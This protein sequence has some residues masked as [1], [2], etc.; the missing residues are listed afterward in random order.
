MNR[1][2]I[3]GQ[4]PPERDVFY[5][6]RERSGRDVTTFRV[7]DGVTSLR[8]PAL[9]RLRGRPDDC[10]GRDEAGASSWPA[11]PG[12]RPEP[13]PD[14]PGPER[15]AAAGQGERP[16]RARPAARR[17]RRGSTTENP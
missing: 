9:R 15:E 2:E 6:T 11:R 12:R 8:V 5:W 17:A 1:F 7:V 4:E 10:P 14:G 13:V 16:A 3:V